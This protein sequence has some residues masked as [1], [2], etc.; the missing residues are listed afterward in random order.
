MR[1]GV[2]RAAILKARVYFRYET[3]YHLCLR[4]NRFVLPLGTFMQK[5]TFASRVEVQSLFLSLNPP[6][7]IVI[8]LGDPPKT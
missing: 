3:R 5:E 2:V 7:I 6:T 8:W 1:F 4:I